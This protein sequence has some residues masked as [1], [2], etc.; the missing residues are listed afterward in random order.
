MRK[1]SLWLVV[2]VAVVGNAGCCRWCDRWC[3]NHHSGAYGPP[4]YVAQ[5]AA[6]VPC[7]PVPQCQPVQCCP[8]P[9]GSS[10]AAGWARSPA[11]PPCQ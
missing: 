4:A 3:G 7:T 8:T 6:C 1:T 9:A 5:P 2:L 11:C 10:P